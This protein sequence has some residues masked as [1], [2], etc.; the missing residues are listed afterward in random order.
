MTHFSTD[1]RVSRLGGK[2]YFVRNIE[3]G[4]RVYSASCSLCIIGFLGDKAVGGVILNTNVEAEN[5]VTYAVTP[6][7][8]RGVHEDVLLSLSNQ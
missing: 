5:E 3:T 6:I 1:G 4:S 8:L 2:R 7:C